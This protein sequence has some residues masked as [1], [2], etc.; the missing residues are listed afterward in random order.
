MSASNGTQSFTPFTTGNAIQARPPVVPGGGGVGTSSTGLTIAYVTSQDGFA[1]GINTADGTQVW[2][3]ASLGTTL[4]GGAAVWLQSVKGLNLGCTANPDLVVVGTKNGDA[5]SNKVY[6]L[7]GGGGDCSNLLK[8]PGAAIWTFSPGNMDIIVSTPFIDYTNNTIWVTSR[9]NATTQA[10]LWKLNAANGTIITRVPSAGPWVDI[11][12]SPSNSLDG[13]FLYVPNNA[14]DLKAIN[15]STNAV[16]ATHTPASGTGA[17]QGSPLPFSF[18]TPSVGTPDTIVFSR[19][20]TVHSVS[21]NGTSFGANWTTTNFP[22]APVTSVSAPIDNFAGT[23]VYVGASDG[24]VHQLRLSDGVDEAQAN[25]V[26]PSTP[27]GGDPSFDI[28]LDRVYVG[29]T[30]G[31]IY[32]FTSPF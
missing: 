24:K 8:S 21:F 2:K 26:G 13:S 5:T 25:L 6:G 12:G 29:A 14:G 15:M 9:S 32:S 18:C 30:D 22:S 4:Q 23:K 20:A 19:N 11:D 16:V 31:H 27:T 28:T 7:H 17:I 1:Y 10:S 3:S